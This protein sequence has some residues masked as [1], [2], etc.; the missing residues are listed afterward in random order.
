MQ[1]WYCAGSWSD[2][3]IKY[4]LNS[5]LS[6]YINSLARKNGFVVEELY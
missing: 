4:A 3:E 1:E 5:V 6:I 2:K